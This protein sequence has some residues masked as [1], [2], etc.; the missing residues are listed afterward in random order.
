MATLQELL[1][2]IQELDKTADH[3]SIG[4]LLTDDVLVAN[5][6]ARLYIC[7]ALSCNMSQDISN[8]YKYAQ[9]AIKLAPGNTYGYLQRGIS[10]FYA[11]DFK[12]AITDLNTVLDTDKQNL[13]AFLQRAAAWYQLQQYEKAIEDYTRAAE[14]D[15]GKNNPVIYYDRGLAKNA[16]SEY[17]SAIKD[18]DKAI[19][20]SKD[21]KYYQAYCDRGVSNFM[22]GYYDKARQDYNKCLDINEGYYLGHYN[23]GLLAHQQQSFDDALKD[24]DRTIELEKGFAPAYNNEGHI[25]LNRG[26]HDKATVNFNKAIELNPALAVGYLNRGIV[27]NLNFK[28]DE[29]L[30]DFMKARDLFDPKIKTEEKYLAFIEDSIKLIEEKF[31]DKKRIES[32]KANPED[33]AAKAAIERNIDLIINRIRDAA[34]SDVTAVVHYTKLLVAEI[35]V[36]STE[37]KIYYSNSIY[38]NDPTEGSVLFEFLNDPVITDTYKKG[39]K[40]SESSIYLGSFLPAEDK[41]SNTAHVDELVMWRTYGKDENGREAAGCSIVIN[42]AFFKAQNSILPGMAEDPSNS[43]LNVIYV[44][45]HLEQKTLQ[46]DPGSGINAALNDLKVELNALIKLKAQ[47]D[48]EELFRIEIDKSVYKR[49]SGISYLFKSSDYEYEHEARI[50]KYIARSSGNIKFLTQTETGKPSKRFYIESLNDVLPH[51]K[52]IYLGPKVENHQQWSLYFDYEIRQR[53]K[54]I[55][56][57][58]TPPFAL[59]PG[60]VKIL[61]SECKF[62]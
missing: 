5:N 13:E 23:R 2:K 39:E 47:P 44:K 34:R 25:Y 52:E 57:M 40:V 46:L 4:E 59:N 43:L 1:D 21:D 19:S 22:L 32:I 35:Y 30:T 26:D 41:K 17:V 38:M 45:N 51:I 18:F 15:L 20:L 55:K 16:L 36:R 11:G 29:A 62:Q 8:A 27:S 50:I 31:A 49:L 56:A 37:A 53:D 6:D 33:K 24:Y 12:N 28:Y 14:F 58:S 3:R 7:K 10:F 9:E 61:R 60:S 54:D 42:S 48:A